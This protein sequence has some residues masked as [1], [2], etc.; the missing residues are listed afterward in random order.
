MKTYEKDVL[1]LRRATILKRLGN[2]DRNL[3][4]EMPQEIPKEVNYCNLH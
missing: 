4:F 2:Q 1:L 3:W